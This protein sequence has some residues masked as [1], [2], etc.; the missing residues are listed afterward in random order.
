[1]LV[2][3]FAAYAF[4]ERNVAKQ[5]AAQKSAATSTLNAIRD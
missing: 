1:M 2:L 3:A 4:H 5:L